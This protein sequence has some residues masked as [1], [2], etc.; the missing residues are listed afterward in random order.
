MAQPTHMLLYLTFSNSSFYSHYEMAVRW[1]FYMTMVGGSTEVRLG[2]SSAFPVPAVVLGLQ[3][4]WPSDLLNL[5]RAWLNIGGSIV[6]C[7]YELLLA[8]I[9]EYL[10]SQRKERM[11]GLNGLTG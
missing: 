8:A 3:K 9:T 4:H 11:E 1:S 10:E 5:R 7:Q 2:L 6:Y